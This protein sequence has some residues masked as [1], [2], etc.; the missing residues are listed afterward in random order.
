MFLYLHTYICMNT[1]EMG[2]ASIIPPNLLNRSNTHKGN[3]LSHRKHEQ[4]DVIQ[5]GRL[6]NLSFLDKNYKA[7]RNIYYIRYLRKIAVINL[8]CFRNHIPRTITERPRHLLSACCQAEHVCTMFHKFNFCSMECF[9]L[10]AQQS[11]A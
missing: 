6:N 1:S 11:I 2:K 8:R 7:F 4:H 3:C 10:R 5:Q 9:L